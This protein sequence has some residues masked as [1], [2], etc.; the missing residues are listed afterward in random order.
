MRADPPS[1]VPIQL[2]L[3]EVCLCLLQLGSRAI[4]LFR[5]PHKF[6]VVAP[7]FVPIAS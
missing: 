4:A 2:T 3:G 5:E 6:R 7:R 1:G